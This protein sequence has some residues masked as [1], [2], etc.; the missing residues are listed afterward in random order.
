MVKLARRVLVPAHILRRA[1]VPE[2]KSPTRD[3]WRTLHRIA[4]S[5]EPEV[6]RRFLEAVR[7][8]QEGIDLD[9]LERALEAGDV[10]AAMRAIPWATFELQF[11]RVPALFAALHGKGAVA[12]AV[13]LSD[14]LGITLAFDLVN[15]R[16]VTWAEQYAAE[17]VREVGQETER[18]IREVVTRG[19]VEGNTAQEMRQAIYGRIGLT[20][21]QQRAVENY[22]TRLEA[23]GVTGA[24]LDRMVARYVERTRRRRA[25]NIARTETIRAAHAGTQDIWREAVML[26]YLPADVQRTWIVTPDDRLCPICEPMHGQLRGLE[27]E[28]TS[29]SNGAATLYPPLH[30]SC[31]CS[32]ALALPDE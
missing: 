27:E 26:G 7:Q 21:R 12:A 23:E 6:R 30:P 24:R 19:F 2:A 32:M 10:N 31:R 4:R 9:A 18:A 22:R 17:L 11:E 28:F 5:G 13:A 1:V 29:P 20:R 16:S 14:M 8:L 3:L 25:E 15:E